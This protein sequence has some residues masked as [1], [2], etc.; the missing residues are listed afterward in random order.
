MNHWIIGLD[1]ARIHLL[2]LNAAGA[3][4]SCPLFLPLRAMNVRGV[5]CL[6]LGRRYVANDH[7]LSTSFSWLL[8]DSSKRTAD[9]MR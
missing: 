5:Q 9:T 4:K 1:S 2:A 8:C 6:L 7:V 3:Y